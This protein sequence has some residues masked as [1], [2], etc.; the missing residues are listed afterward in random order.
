M[1]KTLKF[2]AIL[3][4]LGISM[5]F[6]GKASA[7]I[8]MPSITT[9]Y[10][11]KD[12]KPYEKPL[13]FTIDVYGYQQAPPN[14][15]EKQPGTYTPVKVRS[16]PSDS[17]ENYSCP[18]Y[19]CAIRDYNFPTVKYGHVDYYIFKI[20]SADGSFEVKDGSISYEK[21]CSTPAGG[22]EEYKCSVSV[23]IPSEKKTTTPT[24]VK[25]TDQTQTDDKATTPASNTSKKSLDYQVLFLIQLGQ[26]C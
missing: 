2:V 21:N 14:F 13:T 10:F 8:A 4:V 16:F 9:F 1:K 19:G 5:V 20:K 3:F 18:S 11:Q 17:R 22:Y 26:W 15:E 12:G 24:T 6:A 25:K 7:D 23:S